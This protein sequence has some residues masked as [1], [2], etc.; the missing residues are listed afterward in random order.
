MSAAPTVAARPRAR[1]AAPHPLTAAR[2]P[3]TPSQLAGGKA[4]FKKR[5]SLARL[6]DPQA[7]YELGVM[8]ANGVGTRRD[9]VEALVWLKA[10]AGRGHAAAQYLVAVAH[11]NGMGT[12][13]DE[14][15]A[16]QWFLRAAE[17]GSDKALLKLARRMAEHHD[18]FAF[19]CCLKAATLGLA[20]AQYEVAEHFALGVGV[21]AS[22]VT[23]MQW[24]GRAAKQGVVRAQFALAQMLERA[25]D[26]EPAPEALRWYRAASAQGHPGAQ[27][28][29]ARL[30][31]A[32][33]GR[34][35]DGKRRGRKGDSDADDRR[36]PDQRWDA[37]ALAGDADDRY[38]L[39][40]LYEA[41]IEVEPSLDQAMHWYRLAAEQQHREARIAL[42]RLCDG[43]AALAEEALH[44]WSEA[45][46]AGHAEAQHRLGC[47]HARAD[48]PGHD[49]LQSLAWHLRAAEQGHADALMAV[50]GLLTQGAAPTAAA[51]LRRAAEGGHAQ[52]QFM[53]GQALAAADPDGEAARDAAGVPAGELAADLQQ[54]APDQARQWLERAALQGHADAQCALGDWYAAGRGGG[55]PDF[56]EA[57]ERGQWES[58]GHGAAPDFVQARQWYERA[59]QQGHVRAQWLL[60]GLYATGAVGVARDAKLAT[61]WCKKAAQAGFA[62]AQATLGT[63]FAQ[64][65]RMDRAVSWWSQA[66]AQG[67]AEAQFNLAQAYR[68]GK[69]VPVDLRTAFLLW[70]KAAAA[71]IPAAQTRVGLAYAQGEGAAVDPIEAAKWFMLA[72]RAGDKAAAANCQHA[73][74][75]LS[76]VQLAEAEW[77]A[78]E[79]VP[80]PRQ[81][82]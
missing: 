47:S 36:R 31:R 65:K 27:L 52:A 18:A 21:P 44:W 45:A 41:G 42:A 80:T 69:G 20:E 32:G 22:E 3:E 59:A 61:S 9:P 34:S 6:G 33:A 81:P 55:A 39:G 28:A 23:A 7:Q 10:A 62:P 25:A 76:P 48:G 77:R 13:R 8:H 51:C 71:G 30:D 82:S 14:F 40:C 53:M 5:L 74:S 75:L 35:T 1:G 43:D 15:Q 4:Q 11:A 19:E 46:Q 16:V 2:P 60:G 17:Q 26:G 66:A 67:D 12:E 63:L 72:K 57:S 73:A 58:A 70:S 29:L 24:Y 49:P 56:V 78:K 68:A 64:A 38:H 50:H 79:W 54:G 37:Y